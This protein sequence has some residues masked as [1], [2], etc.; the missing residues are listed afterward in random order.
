M[1]TEVRLRSD[2]KALEESSG[3]I[4][5]SFQRLDLDLCQIEKN[6]YS[7]SQVPSPPFEILGY[8]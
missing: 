4:A 2:L 3:D 8:V 7:T 6:I 1:V 5:L